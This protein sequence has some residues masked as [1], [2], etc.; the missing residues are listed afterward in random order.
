MFGRQII[1]CIYWQSL[2]GGIYCSWVWDWCW[3]CD[4][5]LCSSFK[6]AQICISED[7]DALPLV[8]FDTDFQ[9]ICPCCI[10]SVFS[11]SCLHLKN[12]AFISWGSCSEINIPVSFNWFFDAYLPPIPEIVEFYNDDRLC[13]S[14][15]SVD[16]CNW[17]RGQVIAVALTMLLAQ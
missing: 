10:D 9:F 6:L 1:Y 16:T 7:F 17:I 3:A 12:S 13:S 15:G 14:C 2:C 4:F 11:W 5:S 8:Y